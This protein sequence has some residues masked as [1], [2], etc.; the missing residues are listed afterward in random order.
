MSAELYWNLYLIYILMYVFDSVQYIQAT[1]YSEHLCTMYVC[2][3]LKRLSQPL[4]FLVY[5]WER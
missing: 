4:P 1:Q 2:N 5:I 3:I